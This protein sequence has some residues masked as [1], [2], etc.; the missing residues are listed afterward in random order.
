MARVS[1]ESDRVVRT[2][3]SLIAGMN[4]GKILHFECQNTAP[5]FG[6]Y[7]DDEHFPVY[8]SPC[9]H[10][11]WLCLSHLCFKWLRPAD[12]LGQLVNQLTA[13]AAGP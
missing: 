7:E 10:I 9:G 13:G 12:P 11:L 2:G 4:Y 3:Q 1:S 5:P 6:D 8:A